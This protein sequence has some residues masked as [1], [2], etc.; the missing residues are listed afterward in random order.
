MLLPDGN[1]VT[2]RAEQSLSKRLA[3]GVYTPPAFA[4]NHRPIKIGLVGDSIQA[5]NSSTGA[6]TKHFES[7][8]IIVQFQYRN[9]KRFDFRDE[10][11]KAVGGTRAEQFVANDL[12]EIDDLVA[13]GCEILVDSYGRNDISAGRTAAQLFADRI[14]IHNYAFSAGIKEIWVES[15]KPSDY[16]SNTATYNLRSI[17]CNEQLR[18]DAAN[19]SRKRFIDTWSKWDN[20]SNFPKTGYTYDDIH[21][22]PIGGL[23]GSEAY[24][25]VITP[26]YGRGQGI[27]LSDANIFTNGNFSGT[28]GSTATGTSGDVADGLKAQRSGTTGAGTSAV[29]SKT[30]EGAQKVVFH[31]DSGNTED[32]FSYTSLELTSGFAA[33]KKYR[34]TAEAEPISATGDAYWFGLQVN[35]RDSGNSTLL[36]LSDMD[37]R[38]ENSLID[39]DNT[40]RGILRCHDFIMPE[41]TAELEVRLVIGGDARTSDLDMEVVWHGLQVEELDINILEDFYGKLEAWFNCDSEDNFGKGADQDIAFWKDLSGNGNHATPHTEGGR[42]YSTSAP[43]GYAGTYQISA[44]HDYYFEFDHNY[45]LGDDCTVIALAEPDNSGDESG[46]ESASNAVFTM[47][48]VDSGDSSVSLRSVRDNNGQMQVTSYGLAST[49][50]TVDDLEAWYVRVLSGQVDAGARRNQ[51]DGPQ[52]ISTAGRVVA[53]KF[54]IG[55]DQSSTTRTYPGWIPEVMFFGSGL[56]DLELLSLW[57]YFEKKYGLT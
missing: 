18:E 2:S 33:G 57:D 54:N 10:F 5:A 32:E 26:I 4:D 23:H 40:P 14:A 8:G 47:G 48:D 19:D 6:T 13:R 51:T 20:G 42:E 52:A 55:G 46:G 22:T 38:D 1:L 12:A 49:L 21:A 28:S 16:G 11:N 41:D 25:E 43:S 39:M 15:V 56:S 36:N 53:S 27:V 17:D 35:C 7:N 34:I 45:T 50:T 30:A 24:D 31:V 44:N 29:Y 37:R 3:S 9:F